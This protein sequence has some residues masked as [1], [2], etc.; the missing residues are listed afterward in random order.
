MTREETV[1]IIRIMCDCYPNYKPNNLSETVDVW[2]SILEKHDMNMISSGLKAYIVSD[3]SGFPPSIGQIIKKAQDIAV[4]N[5]KIS[6]MEAWSLVSSAIRNSCYNS[7]AEFSK[8]PKI[9]QRSVGSPRQLRTWAIDENYNESVVSSNFIKCYRQQLD[10][11][12]TH[13]RI[14]G[15]L[16]NALDMKVEPTKIENKTVKAKNEDTFGEVEI[17]EDVLKIWKEFEEKISE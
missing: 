14:T 16:N 15:E 5:D 4:S 13:L 11:Q 1:K 7:E 6:E 2:S 17:S 3:A 9:V 10:N 8:L 12:M